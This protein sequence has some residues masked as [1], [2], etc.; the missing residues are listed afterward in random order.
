MTKRFTYRVRW[1]REAAQPHDRPYT[2]VRHY[3]TLEAAQR[4]AERQK[5]AREDMA[6]WFTD[7]DGH[8]DWARVP[9]AIVW[10]P[11][12]ERRAVLSEWEPTD[13]TWDVSTAAAATSLHHDTGRR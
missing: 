13:I 6:E 2:T 4:C 5:T 9:R 10:R 8:T 11:V 12:I 7:D 3:E 1:Q